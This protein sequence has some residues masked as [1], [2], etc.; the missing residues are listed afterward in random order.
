MVKRMSDSI[1]AQQF[2]RGATSEISQTRS[3]WSRQNIYIRPEGTGGHPP[4]NEDCFPSSL[5]D[6]SPAIAHQTLRVWLISMVASRLERWQFSRCEYGKP[7][8]GL[9]RPSK[10][11]G[12]GFVREPEYQPRHKVPA[13]QAMYGRSATTPTTSPPQKL[14]NHFMVSTSIDL[15]VTE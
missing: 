2:G 11:V 4:M 8:F 5:Q 12:V 9:R 13:P 15:S 3:V 6:A 14:S 7:S 1:S 10:R